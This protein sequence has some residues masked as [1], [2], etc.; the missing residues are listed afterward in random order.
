MPDEIGPHLLGRL[1][2]TLDERDYRA[3]NFLTIGE[4]SLSRRATADPAALIDAGVAELKRTQTSYPRWAAT[5]YSDVTTT[6]WWRALDDFALAKSALAP[7]P[8]PPA[9]VIWVDPDS[10]LDQGST[11]H[12]GGFGGAQ[13]GNTE[14][15]TDHYDNADAHALYYESV[16]IGGVPRTENGVETRWVA[17]ALQARARLVSYAFALTTAEVRQ[18]VQDK[19]PVMVGSDWTDDMFDPDAQGFIVPSGPVAG[20]H[21]WVIVGDLVAESAFLCLNSWGASWGLDGRFKIRHSDFA[22]LLSGIYT[23]GDAI[24][25]LEL[26]L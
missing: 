14:P 2:T 8:P 20:G 18:W 7:A 3:S 22:K 12:C 11:P 26:P 15:V 1:P 4:H 23:P 25:S 9:D 16:A 13:W 6:H 24:V 19:G 5:K 21:F 10:V 17:K